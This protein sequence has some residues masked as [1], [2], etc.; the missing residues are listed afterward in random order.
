MKRVGI[1]IGGTFTDV[2]ILDEGSGHTEVLKVA[3]TP[4][5][6]SEAPVAALREAIRTYQVDPRA[7]R[8]VSHGSTVG[9]NTVIERKGAK[10]G[11]ITTKGFRDV[12]ELGRVAR[13]PDLLYDIYQDRPA[14]LVPRHLRREVT[15]RVNY[16]GEVA[17]AL[18]EEEVGRVIA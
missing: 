3:S 13:P 2:L 6:I 10:T 14:V 1:D 9:T 4:E 8:F 11:L 16:K 17:T 15:E 12:L 5:E 7:I 18:D